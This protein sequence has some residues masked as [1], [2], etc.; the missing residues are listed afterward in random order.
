MKKSKK[1]RRRLDDLEAENWDL[2][3]ELHKLGGKVVD[4]KSRVVTMQNSYTQKIMDLEARIA[5]IEPKTGADFS[6][7][8]IMEEMYTRLQKPSLL[9]S[10]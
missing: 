2:E 6:G 3:S 9:E 7:D 8:M 1:I 10:D 4:L 5:A